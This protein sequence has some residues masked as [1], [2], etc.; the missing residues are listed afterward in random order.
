[1][2]SVTLGESRPSYVTKGSV[3]GL[4]SGSLQVVSWCLW[5]EAI[6]FPLQI[7]FLLMGN[8]F[9]SPWKSD[10]VQIRNKFDCWEGNRVSLWLSHITWLL[11]ICS[12]VVALSVCL[13]CPPGS[14]DPCDSEEGMWTE[15]G[16]AEQR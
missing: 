7:N 1:M 10:V 15:G 6:H 5:R 2:S 11:S 4:S 16:R 9:S 12:S 8:V 3:W 13:H 14:L